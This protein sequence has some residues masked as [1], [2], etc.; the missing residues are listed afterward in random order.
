M[1]RS[2]F[3]PPQDLKHTQT[4]KKITALCLYF[5]LCKTLFAVGV[6]ENRGIYSTNP[7][8][9]FGHEATITIDGD[10]SDWS[11][12]LIIAQGSAN[13]MCTTFKGMHENSVLDCYALFAAW[14]DSNLYL[15]W[16]MVNTNDL[17]AREGD[18]PLSDGGRIADVPL[19][20]ALSIDPTAK[21]TGRLS[22]GNMLW[23]KVDVVYE[24][25]VDRIFM[26][27]GKAGQGDPAMFLAADAA[28][29]TS[30]DAAYCKKYSDNGISYKMGETFGGSTHLWYLNAPTDTADIYAEGS[31]WVDLNDPTSYAGLI[32]KTHN[33]KYD[34]FYE[35]K[36][37]LATLGIDKEYLTQ[38]G[39]GA[40]MIATRGE[41]GIDCLPH[42][43]SMIDDV[44][45]DYIHDKSTSSEKSDSDTIR[46]Q[47]A[48]I[49]CRRAGSAPAPQPTVAVSIPDGYTFYSET[50]EVRLRS[51]DAKSASYSID[52]GA[53]VPFD[54]QAKIEVG[55]TLAAGGK[56]NLTVTATNNQG[57]VNRSYAYT[58]GEAFSVGVGT[59]IA[60]KPADWAEI[61]CY[62]YNGDNKNAEWPGLPM[63]HLTGDYYA[64]SLP[65][66]WSVGNV[67][68]TNGEEDEAK[69]QYPKNGGLELKAGEVKLWDWTRWYNVSYSGTSA[70]KQI[71]ADGLSVWS[72]G[73][74]LFVES[75]R[76]AD[77][78]LYHISGV[79]VG[80]LHLTT[81]T[82]TITGL[83]AGVYLLNGQKIVVSK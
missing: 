38:T 52:G 22:N 64:L 25:P 8:N 46:Y 53:A 15:A 13:D 56:V 42:D 33:K 14:D 80:K 29:N 72:W 59:A 12:D 55:S 47:L 34:S 2:I 61:Y 41:S 79:A 54:G 26:M 30:Y 73:N 11:D 75:D 9:Q 4:M 83:A 76:D 39:I 58:K 78:T 31:T 32:S 17:W 49:G 71:A 43:H 36:I 82:T 45:G 20:I 81:G 35:M 18:G 1:E 16:Q 66:G 67:I 50:L 19:V 69:Q 48:D 65:S 28:G 21:M 24:T 63:T 44:Y 40:M 3:E 10:P 7:N 23:D 6:V 57:D 60:V 5:A 37:P 74:T 27:S 51:K 70:V 62:M 68:F 77:C